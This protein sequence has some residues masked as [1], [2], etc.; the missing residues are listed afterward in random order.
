LETKEREKE[1]EREGGRER[2]KATIILLALDLTRAL[3]SF[4]ILRIDSSVCKKREK[5]KEKKR[6]KDMMMN[7]TQAGTWKKG[8]DTDDFISRLHS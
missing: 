5:E 4:V 8:K 1:I 6:K 3:G 2:E 7:L